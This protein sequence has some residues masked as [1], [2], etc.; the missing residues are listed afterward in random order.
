MALGPSYSGEDYLTDPLTIEQAESDGA[1][2]AEQ[3]GPGKTWE[4]KFEYGRLYGVID[5][6]AAVIQFAHKAILT[7]RNKHLAYSDQY[8]CELHD[9]IG[10]ETTAGYLE[11]EI[12]RMVR[13]ALVYDDRINDV[14]NVSF[15]LEEDVLNIS[16]TLDTIY[17]TTTTEV[18][19]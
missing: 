3:T 2:T 16:L 15:T 14:T 6:I 10:A 5:E 12:P 9:L 8:G 18:V 13:E 17:G 19:I 11:A 7:A 4:I 1:I